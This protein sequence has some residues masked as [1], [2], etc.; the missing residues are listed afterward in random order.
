MQENKKIKL[1][2]HFLLFLRQNCKAYLICQLFIQ[3]H[4]QGKSF[5]MTAETYLGYFFVLSPLCFTFIYV[6]AA[7][8][9]IQNLFTFFPCLDVLFWR[10]A[11]SD[12][13]SLMTNFDV[14]KK[15]R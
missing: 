7:V 8:C 6:I 3:K 5:S 4:T 11:V 12:F 14:Y 9:G 10:C 2:L 15:H 13:Q 1:K